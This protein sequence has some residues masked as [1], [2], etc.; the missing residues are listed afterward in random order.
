VTSY[1]QQNGFDPQNEIAYCRF[2]ISAISAFSELNIAYSIFSLCYPGYAHSSYCTYNKSISMIK[3]NF[4]FLMIF[5][6]FIGTIQY[7]IL[8]DSNKNRVIFSYYPDGLIKLTTNLYLIVMMI[9]TI[10]SG[11]LHMRYLMVKGLTVKY[12]PSL[13]IH[14]FMGIK[15]PFFICFLILF[16]DLI[17]HYLSIILDIIISIYTFLIPV[18]FYWKFYS[19]KSSYCNS[20]Y[21]IILIVCFITQIVFIFYF[22]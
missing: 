17:F 1:I 5:F 3:G 12:E 10:S 16:N 20:F 13:I 2:D 15:F 4:I 6:S 14:F 18:V 9:F 11:F 22:I 7:L 8:V 21:D 19:F